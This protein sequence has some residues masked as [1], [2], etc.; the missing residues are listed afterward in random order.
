MR[1]TR[2]K[3]CGIARAEDALGAAEAGADA[4]GLVFHAA[5]PRGVTVE[6]ARRILDALPPFVTA[7]ALFVSSPPQEAL[8]TAAD[9]GLSTV[10][11]HG[12][13]TPADAAALA[14]LRVVKALAVNDGIGAALEAWRASR[15]ANLAGLLLDSAAGG[16][17]VANDFDAIARLEAA[18]VFEGLPRRTIAGGLRPENV[19]AVVRRLRPWAVDVSS[20]VESSRGVKS[21][22]RM[23]AFVAAVRGADGLDAPIAGA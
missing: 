19:G 10:Q 14:P 17:G 5:S 6:Q 16:S 22:D 3:I 12:Q 8:R 9:L 23:R 2:I 11:L 18:G 13:E 7:T 4:I 15:P 1:R 20:G 21:I